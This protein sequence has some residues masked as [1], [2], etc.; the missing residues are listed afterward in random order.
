MHE[1]KT[2]KPDF[3]KIGNKHAE[4][5]IK[6]MLEDSPP[7]RINAFTALQQGFFRRGIAS[8]RIVDEAVTIL[9]KVFQRSCLGKFRHDRRFPW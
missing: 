3:S 9:S 1:G 2:Y 4:G 8:S 7:L 6:R 5:V